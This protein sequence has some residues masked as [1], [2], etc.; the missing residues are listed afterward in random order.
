MPAAG[1]PWY[2]DWTANEDDPNQLR[3]LSRLLLDTRRHRQAEITAYMANAKMRS[4]LARIAED[5][6][7]RATFGYP[8]L[9]FEVKPGRSTV[10]VTVAGMMLSDFPE[11]TRDWDYAKNTL[12]PLS[13][14]AGCDKVA[15]WKCHRCGHEWPAEVGQRTK[16]RTRCSACSTSWATSATS[17]AAVHPELVPEWDRTANLPRIPEKMKAP[18]ARP[19]SG[20]AAI[21][22]PTTPPTACRRVLERSVPSAVGSA[23]RWPSGPT[24]R[25]PK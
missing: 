18:P 2:P 13:L 24:R 14:T 25:S 4:V 16:R 19:S 9:E 20:D 21:S 1:A 3:S 23:A 17:V 6:I 10:S 15:H 11:V 22:R 12:D 7:E 5:N 8:P